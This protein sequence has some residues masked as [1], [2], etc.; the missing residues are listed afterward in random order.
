[1]LL[2][3]FDTDYLTS[4]SAKLDDYSLKYRELDTKCYTQIEDYSLTSVQSVAIKGISKA[5]I[6]VGKFIE[7][8]PVIGDAQVDETLIAGG[9]KLDE[10]SVKKRRDKMS[11]LIVYQSNCVR[12]FIEN[13][14]TINELYNKPLQRLVDKDSLYFATTA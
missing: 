8:I 6:T 7:K 3:N 5:S 11:S 2:E 13:I 10:L 14:D 4:V 9:E 1:M 12:P